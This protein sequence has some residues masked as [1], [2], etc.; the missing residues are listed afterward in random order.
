MTKVPGASEVLSVTFTGDYLSPVDVVVINEIMYNPQ[1]TGQ[2]EWIELYNPNDQGIALNGFQLSDG[3]MDNLFR[4]GAD[5][6]IDP[7]GYLVVAGDSEL[8]QNEHS[9]GIYFTGSFNNGESGFRL[10][11]EGESIILKNHEGE[12]E[13]IVQ[14]DNQAPW[15]EAADGMGPSLQLLA[16]DLDNN[17]YSNWFTSSGTL[18]S[19]GSENGG[20]SAE[21]T[22]ILQPIGGSGDPPASPSGPTVSYTFT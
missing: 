4:F 11:N 6:V 12:L 5:I 3:G 9:S 14:Y 15:P 8:F 17:H 18:Y 10:S 7:R 16:P 1:L 22:R 2:S 21:V 13:D 19:P 20:N